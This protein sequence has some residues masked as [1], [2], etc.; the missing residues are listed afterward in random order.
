M[1]IV[2]VKYLYLKQYVVHE[3]K[4]KHYY[5]VVVILLGQF[6]GF[7]FG[8][9]STAF[10]IQP[11]PSNH[12]IDSIRVIF[13]FLTLIASFFLSLQ[14][15]DTVGVPILFFPSYNNPNDVT[16]VM[17]LEEMLTFVYIAP[18]LLN[19]HQAT[20]NGRMLSITSP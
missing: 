10:K 16:C 4:L 11:I 14:Q 7:Y 12:H 17:L 2:N 19:C 3:Q 15:I 8:T 5:S 6:F 13:L 18:S 1:I 9:D 20:P